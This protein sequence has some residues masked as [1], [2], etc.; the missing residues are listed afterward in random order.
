RIDGSWAV[1]GKTV[2]SFA[3]VTLTGGG[4]GQDGG[5]DGG[6]GTD[7][8]TDA[9]TSSGGLTLTSNRTPIFTNVGDF[10]VL[11]ATLKSQPDGGGTP[12]SGATINFSTT[13]GTLG[14]GD[15]G[16]STGA[17]YAEATNGSGQAFTLL[18]AGA[19]AGTATVTATRAGAPT[20]TAS[21]NVQI[22]DIRQIAWVSTACGA[23]S[24]CNLMGVRGSGKNEVATLTFAV[25]DTSS[26]PAPRIPV[27]FSLGSGA[28]LGAT[29][30]PSGVTNSAGQVTA[31]LQSGSGIGVVTVTATVF[32]PIQATSPGLGITGARVSNAGIS[33]TCSTVNIPA[34]ISP[35]PPRDVTVNCAVGLTDRYTNPIGFPTTVNF[36]AEAGTVSTSVTTTGFNFSNPSDPLIGRANFTFRTLAGTGRALPVDVAPFPANATQDP[37]PRPAEPSLPNGSQTLNPRDG[38]VTIVAYVNG[39]EYFYDANGNGVYDSGEQFYDQGERLVD[40]NDNGVFDLGENFFDENNNGSWDGPDGTWQSD[41]QVWTEYR[42]MYTDYPTNGTLVPNPF[43]GACGSGLG[44]GQ[45][46]NLTLY[47]ADRNLN[48]P[49]PGTTVAV[50]HTASKGSV[51]LN[52]GTTLLDGY[53]FDMDRVLVNPGTGRLCQPTDTICH[54]RTQ[55]YAWYVGGISSITVTGA[56]PSDVTPCAPDTVTATVTELGVPF[57]FTS[58]GAIE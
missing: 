15:A 31:T 49:I 48:Q 57:G 33:V 56:S 18:R 27:T 7:G 9:G 28:P 20:T 13:L 11:T 4:T 32:A 24:P 40:A 39:E 51:R 42:L 55:F 6:Q 26:N 29:V 30:T 37:N 50:A 34:Y 38:L 1:N 16:A 58:S 8:G 47:A 35:T 23:T 17:S 5:G 53:G 3:N 19:V 10:A 14:P 44:K 25:T 41:K 36:V 12:V 2:T 46:V 54:F 21:A 45:S 52:G 22:T 43:S